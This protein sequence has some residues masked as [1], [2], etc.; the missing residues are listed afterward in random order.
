MEGRIR[1][2]RTEFVE[3]IPEK[4]EQGVL[5]VSERGKTAAH[6]CACGC[7]ERIDT[8]LK[9]LGWTLKKTGDGKVSLY[10][11]IENT[12]LPCRSHY[13]IYKGMFVWLS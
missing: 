7:G 4:L 12:D 3:T 11:S 6:L 10:P 9:W 5:Y 2:V 13:Y 8:P 1:T